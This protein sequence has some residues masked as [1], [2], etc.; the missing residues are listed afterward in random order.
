[1]RTQ[2]RTL[3]ILRWM[4]TPRLSE[5]RNLAPAAIIVLAAT[6]LVVGFGVSS[7]HERSLGSQASAWRGLVGGARPSVEVGQRMLVVLRAPSLAQ[8]V[9]AHGG[10][11]TQRQEHVWTRD[12]IGTQKRLLTELQ[13]SEEH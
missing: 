10:L 5:V 7:T 2:S 9:A 12:A 8:R 3:V 11:A 6:L 13:R 4:R 1:M